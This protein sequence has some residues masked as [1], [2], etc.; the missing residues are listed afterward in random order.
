MI[1]EIDFVS[2]CPVE[3]C[4]NKNT[5]YKW[6]HYN[7]GGREKI[8]NEGKIYC[9]KCGTDGLFTDWEFNCGAHDFKEASAQ[10]FCHALSVMAQLDTKNQMFIVSLM[11]KVGEQFEKKYKKSNDI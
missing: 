7:C 2:P 3:E 5:S 11:G 10:G 1:S 4:K 8:T 6:S 9:L